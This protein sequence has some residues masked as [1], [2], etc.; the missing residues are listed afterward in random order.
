MP[1][2]MLIETVWVSQGYL[3][4]LSITIKKTNNKNKIKL[5]ITMKIKIQVI[6]IKN[7]NKY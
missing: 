7:L 2:S 4:K 5:N 6:Q 3:I 1:G